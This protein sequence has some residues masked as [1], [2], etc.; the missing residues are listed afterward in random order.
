MKEFNSCQSA[1][2]AC[3]SNKYFAIAH[4]FFEEK[5]MNIHIH[6]CYEIY[7][8]ISGGKQ[9]LIDNKAYKIE[10]GDLFFIN[11]YES[12]YLTQIDHEEHERIVISIHPDFLRSISTPATELDYCFLN[13]SPGFSHRISLDKNQQQR[14]MYYIHK[15]TS[16][17]GYAEDVLERIAITELMV[18]FNKEFHATQ[19]NENLTEDFNYQYDQQ[20]NDILEYINQNIGEPLTIQ[21]LADHFFLSKSFICRIFKQS[22]GTTVN[23]YLTAR[24]ISIAKALLSEGA[25]VNEVYEQCGFLDYSTFLKAFTKTVGLS[26]KKYSMYNNRI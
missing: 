4:L 17:S 9:F 18:F 22:T 19:Q 24:R 13:R 21:Q 10:P 7:Y 15:I 25:S 26:P 8:S 1:I 11:Q 20:V 16:L 14:F 12:H 2:N 5:T 6:D 3:I 23:K